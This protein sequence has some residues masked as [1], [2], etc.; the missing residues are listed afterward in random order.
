MTVP[1][2]I[3][4]VSQLYISTEKLARVRAWLDPARMPPLPVRDFGNGRLTLTDGHT[5]AVA[6]YLAG[7]REV[8]VARDDDPIFEDPDTVR[9]YRADIEWCD[10]HGIKCPADLAEQLVSGP[11][12]EILWDRRCDRGQALVARKAPAPDFCGLYLYGCEPDGSAFYYE[13][14]D[15][16]LYALKREGQ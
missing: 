6:A 8:P 15:G 9:E 7:L 5:R 3:L 12:Y 13:D 4:G 16:T 2:A 10:R 1:I 14:A 11:D